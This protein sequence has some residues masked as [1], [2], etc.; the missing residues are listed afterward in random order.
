MFQ[1]ILNFEGLTNR[2]FNIKIIKKYKNENN[3]NFISSSSWINA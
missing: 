2:T 1:T 3:K